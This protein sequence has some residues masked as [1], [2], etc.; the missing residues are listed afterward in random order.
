[1]SFGYP[2]RDSGTRGGPTTQGIVRFPQA[3]D[4]EHVEDRAVPR[5]ARAA[6]RRPDPHRPRR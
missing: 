3:H 2:T 5:Y 1:M 6:R 4:T